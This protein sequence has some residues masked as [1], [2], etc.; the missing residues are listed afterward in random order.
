M[1]FSDTVKQ[2]EFLIC[3]TLTSFF[4]ISAISYLLFQL[5]TQRRKLA[6]GFW[7]LGIDVKGD[8]DIKDIKEIED[9]LKNRRTRDEEDE[10]TEWDVEAYG[11]YIKKIEDRNQLG[12]NYVVQ[13]IHT[14]L[15]TMLGLSLFIW[16]PSRLS[17][18]NEI[19]GAEDIGKIIIQAM[20]YGFLGAYIFSLQLVYRRYSTFDLQPIVY[21]NCTLT[22]IAGIVF[23]FVAFNAINALTDTEGLEA[24]NGFTAGILAII[25]FSLGY[26]PLLAI[27]WFNR[28]AY[29]ALGE[30]RRRA[31]ALPLGLIDGISQFHETR[32]WDEGIDNLQNLASAAIDELLINTR[33]SAPEVI[34]W[35]DQAILY[36][37]LE[38]NQIEIFR[39]GGIR[40]FSDLVEKWGGYYRAYHEGENE[41]RRL[42]D[43]L[44]KIRN[45]G[46]WK[47]QEP[48]MES[49]KDPFKIENKDQFKKD[50]EQERKGHAQQLTT[51]PEYLDALYLATKKGPNVALVIHYWETLENELSYLKEARK[52]DRGEGKTRS[53]RH[54]HRKSEK[55]QEKNF[56]K[57][58]F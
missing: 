32:L 58:N 5:G 54:N 27:R 23:N 22:I 1:F 24:P 26:F 55:S 9:N 56:S 51:T 20:Q 46:S 18:I 10:N 50:L 31:N 8:L 38:K 15:A 35:V 13:S 49:D 6:R 25:A 7:L 12:T 57:L 47:R 4:P 16:F 3:L 40:S 36:L 17:L 48:D 42:V 34:D 19:F 44:R 41:M 33:F 39:R 45:P 14:L 52:T 37:Y 21:M 53:I 43:K 28:M 2:L 11:E 30:E 29:K